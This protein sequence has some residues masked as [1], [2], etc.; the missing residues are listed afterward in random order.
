MRLAGLILSRRAVVFD[1]DGTLVSQAIDYKAVRETVAEL[2][3]RHGVP[4]ALLSPSD[5]VMVMLRRSVEYLSA[6]GVPV[7]PVVSEVDRV[8]EAFE[9]EAASKTNLI[10]G[11]VELLAFLKERG[12]KLGL[13]TL[14]KRPAMMLVARRFNLD[15]FMDAMVSR[16]DA[17]AP[18]PDPRHLAAV[19][20]KLSVEAR[21]TVVVGDHPVDV[22]CAVKAGAAA[23]GVLSSGR[24]RR[25]LEEAGAWA[26]VDSVA[27]ILEDLKAASG[28]SR[29]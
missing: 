10:P 16:D 2:L 7:D 5:G 12:F 27:S 9:L 18:K 29:E 19:L 17:P 21:E 14:N 8:V 25:E 20:S 26:V 23:I 1:C 28:P 3:R 4:G 24:S 6:R 11:A 13:F 22:E 15:R